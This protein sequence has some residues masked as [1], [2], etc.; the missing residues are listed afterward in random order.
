M[1]I[2]L[3]NISVQM[4]APRWVTARALSLFFSALTGGIALGAWMWGSVASGWSVQYAIVASGIMML[5][6]PLLSFVLPL[7][8]AVSQADIELVVLGNEPDVGMAITL[9]SGPVVI[10]ID[11]TVDPDRAR[12]FYEAMRKVQRTRLRNGG[13]DWSICRDIADPT[14]WTERYHCPTWGDYLRMRDRYTQA[15][16][17]VQETARAFSTLGGLHVRRRLER[18]YG[19]VRWKQDTPDPKAEGIA[20][21]GP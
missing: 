3:L 7:P 20:Y 13:F 19:S 6:L 9:R 12:E 11:Y 14:I 16:S 4:T 1:M 21:I 2:S 5:I 15:D 8:A 10:E 17:D 18:P